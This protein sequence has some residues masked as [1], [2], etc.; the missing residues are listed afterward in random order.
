MLE[1]IYLAATSKSFRTSRL[2]ELIAHGETIASVKL[3]VSQDGGTHEQTLGLQASGGARQAR[4]DGKRPPSLAAFAVKTP[5]VV[6]HPGEVA[7]STGPSGERRRL[8]DR[9]VL[10][11]AFA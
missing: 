6:F 3:V 8:L 9:V 5:M 4:I 1:G 11:T 7:L 10:H 2:Q